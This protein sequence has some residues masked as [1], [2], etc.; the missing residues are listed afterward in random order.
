VSF[1]ADNVKTCYMSNT[2]YFV[3]LYACQDLSLS[4]VKKLC[5]FGSRYVRFDVLPYRSLYPDA[6]KEKF[7]RK[8]VCLFSCAFYIDLYIN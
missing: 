8:F 1:I 6:S 2:V 4:S 7:L 5:C 3:D